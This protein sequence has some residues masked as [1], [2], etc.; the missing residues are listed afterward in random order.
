MRSREATLIFLAI[1]VATFVYVGYQYFSPSIV[2]T[3]EVDDD[4]LPHENNN[5]GLLAGAVSYDM[6][7]P[8]SFDEM[9]VDLTQIGCETIINWTGGWHGR[10]D[11]SYS[12]ALRLAKK[13]NWVGVE[14]D[15]IG[16]TFWLDGDFWVWTKPIIQQ[17]GY[18]KIEI[19]QGICTYNSTATYW[20]I[21][22]TLKNTG[23][24]SS[25]LVSA[26]INNVEVMIYD[27][28]NYVQASTSTSMCEGL[29]IA[30]GNTETIN[31]YI[32]L[33]Y[34]SLSS[35]TTINIKIHSAGGMDYI[36]LVELV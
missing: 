2:R 36:K 22:L 18:E 5:A 33:G 32:D 29:T 8:G 12:D 17:T 1:L 23:T 34:G 3:V 20:R 7:E 19:Q 28:D 15:E 16:F 4:S 31:L 10:R 35:G 30:S 21:S 26:F 25:T 14:P 27:N 13:A 6:D 24:G 9:I 11:L